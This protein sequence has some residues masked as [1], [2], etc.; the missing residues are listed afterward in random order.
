MVNS[1]QARAELEDI[2]SDKEYRAYYNNSKSII[3]TL[4]DK[5]NEW[6]AEQLSKLFPSFEPTGTMT[7][8][9]L[10][11]TIVI[12][13]A[14]LL[15]ILFVVVRNR[16]CTHKFREHKPLHSLSEMKWSYQRHLSE[17]RTQEALGE[18][19]LATRHMFLA[20]L[21]SFH[22]KEWLEARVWKTNWEY[23]DEL[24]KVNRKGADQFY[25]LALLFDEVTYGE[26]IVHKQEY[27]H[28]RDETMKWLE[29][30][31]EQQRSPIEG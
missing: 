25:N 22:E 14:L 28:Y 4:W 3:E 9:S 26:R 15:F 2:L 29:V 1:D 13:T 12:V 23:Y 8:T 16:T 10:I 5:A 24:L 20:L 6:L 11:I 18:Y 21:L 30:E 19:N 31:N 27:F 7:S 17:A